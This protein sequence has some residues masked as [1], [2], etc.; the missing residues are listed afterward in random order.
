M[1]DVTLTPMEPTRRL[2]LD[3]I[4]GVLFT[5]RVT[6]ARIASIN[7]GVW[8]LPILILT[9]TAILAT[10]VAGPIKLRE[11]QMK[12]PDLPPDFQYYSP[13][14]QAQIMQ[15]WEA[16]Q[17]PVFYLCLSWFDRS[18]KG[19]GGMVD[20]DRHLAF[21]PDHAWRS[22]QRQ[23]YFEYCSLGRLAICNSRRCTHHRYA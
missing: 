11:A 22:R 23:H 21:I 4:P 19:V 20:G 2:P 10:V 3:W 1:A 8:F 15:A 14:Q 18:W 13:E 7:R 12:G 17:K 16:T 9:L 6:L 5:P